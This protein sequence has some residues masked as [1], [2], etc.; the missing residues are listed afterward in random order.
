MSQVLSLYRDYVQ[1]SR[2]FLYP[3]LG[4]RRGH[5]VTPI[6]TYI[7]LSNKYTA[8]DS[9]L[10]CV[11]Y[12]RDDADFKI[13]ESQKLRGNKMFHEAIPIGEDKIAYVFDF[14]SQ[15]EDFN[16]FLQGKYS[17]I[18]PAYKQTI[19]NFFKNNVHVESYLN[20][21]KFIPMYADLLASERKD[22]PGLA[23]LLGEIGELCSPPDLEKETLKIDVSD[24]IVTR[25]QLDL[26]S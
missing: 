21:M 17:R 24:G 13:L 16:A 12:H 25:N 6:E 18:S 14:S 19:L 8:E 10:I 5:S 26:Q 23:K 1:K 11:Y 7:S 20:P 3:A 4:I 2:M 15:Q 9:K 22:V